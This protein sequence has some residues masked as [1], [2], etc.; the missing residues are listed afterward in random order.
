M[1]YDIVTSN[2][3]IIPVRLIEFLNYLSVIRGRS[4]NTVTGYKIEISLFFRF[5]K[6]YNGLCP[7]KIEFENIEINDI[8]D[9]FIKS[10]KLSD[11]YAFFIFC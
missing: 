4:I 7:P 6:L 10:I 2:S 5:I 11:F 9:D 1:R 8:G 3:E